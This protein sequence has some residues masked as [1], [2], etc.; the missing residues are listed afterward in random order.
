MTQNN[1]RVE[2]ENL[3]KSVYTDGKWVEFMLGQFLSNAVKY[4]SASPVISIC[5]EESDGRTRLTIKDNGI[6][7]PISEL[8]RIFEKGFTGSN[9]RTLG[10]S[11]GMGLYLCRK[12]AEVLGVHLEAD[13]REN[14]YTAISICFPRP[15]SYENER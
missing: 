5:A 6:G 7:I 3:D 15:L 14:K 12:L 2:T 11:T 8:R 9:G 13:S 4:R 10:G 1:M